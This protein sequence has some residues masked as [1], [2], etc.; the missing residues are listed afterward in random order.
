M[1]PNEGHKGSGLKSALTPTA[2]AK[3]S[4]R[5]LDKRD[6]SPRQ[7]QASADAGSQAGEAEGAHGG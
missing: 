4:W 7:I 3:T 2:A 5:L 1:A 6:F